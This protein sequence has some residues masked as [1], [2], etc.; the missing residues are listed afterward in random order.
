MFARKEHIM[1]NKKACVIFTEK[2]R[3]EADRLSERLRAEGYNVCATEVSAQDAK[4][5]VAKDVSALPSE[6]TACLADAEVCVLL[7]D[8]EAPD[9]FDGLAG[10]ASDGGCRVVSVGGAPADLSRDLDDLIDGH[11]P[12]VDDPTLID[13][14]NGKPHRI[15]PDKSPEAERKEPRVKC[16]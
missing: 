5:L 4:A 14:V 9:M 2:K 3:D 15:K 8:D 7:I 11:L 12:D 1:A 13:V 10:L 6:V 16:Q